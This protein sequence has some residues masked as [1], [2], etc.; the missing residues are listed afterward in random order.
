MAVPHKSFPILLSDIPIKGQL[1]K[2][3]LCSVTM[4]YDI[5]PKISRVLIGIFNV[6]DLIWNFWFIHTMGPN[7]D[8]RRQIY[9]NILTLELLGPLVVTSHGNCDISNLENDT[10]MVDHSMSHKFQDASNGFYY[11][12]ISRR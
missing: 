10:E 6:L 3:R 2:W 12:S 4:T 11:F 7:I 9:L 5:W 8:S 1:A